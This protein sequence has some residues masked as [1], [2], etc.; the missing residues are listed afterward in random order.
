MANFN[1]ITLIGTLDSE[2]DEKTTTQGHNVANFQ[3]TVKRPSNPNTAV[4][5]EKTDTFTVVCWN[6]LATKAIELKQNSLLLVEGRINT[7]T[8]DTQDGI[9]KWITEIEARNV[10]PFDNTLLNADAADTAFS[11][12]QTLNTAAFEESQEKEPE[13]NFDDAPADIAQAI[14]HTEENSTEDVPF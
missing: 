7:R 4:G 12:A 5:I 2:I 14:N 3:L 11:D 1:K 10:T 6:E 8:F 9:R 13:F